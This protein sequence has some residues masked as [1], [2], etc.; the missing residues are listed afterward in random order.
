MAGIYFMAPMKKILLFFLVFTVFTVPFARADEYYYNLNDTKFT[1][2][3]LI[4]K[5]K[6]VLFVWAT[7]CP[8]CRKKVKEFSGTENRRDDVN[9]V[10][11]ETGEPR[12]EVLNTI[13]NL[14]IPEAMYSLFYRDPFQEI[15]GRF[16][17]QTVPTVIFFQD[18]K[19]VKI[20][21]SLSNGLIDEV[22]P[23]GA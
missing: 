5:A 20:S 1:Y 17:I 13:K 15:I 21:H 8:T 12:S 19:I 14:E 2:D 23:P 11:L 22:Y 4:S 16:T 7:W 3:E 18:G 6:T 9:I 10:F